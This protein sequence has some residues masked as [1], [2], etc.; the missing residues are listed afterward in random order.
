MNAFLCVKNTNFQLAFDDTLFL[1]EFILHQLENISNFSKN[2]EKRKT[3]SRK[4]RL[5]DGLKLCLNVNFVH[6]K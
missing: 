1:R 5:I 3:N 2:F 6:R 4:R